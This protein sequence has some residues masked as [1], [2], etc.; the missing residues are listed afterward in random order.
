M[1]KNLRLVLMIIA[2]GLIL[3]PA[4]VLLADRGPSAPQQKKGEKR[5]G[6]ER[7]RFPWEDMFANLPEGEQK[8][9][10]KL[11]ME[12][13]A[14][15]RKEMFKL[16]EARRKKQLDELLALRKAY[17]NA[18]EGAEKE[19]AK[20][21]LRKRIEEN[22]KRHSDRA[23]RRIR[24]MEKQLEQLQKRVDIARKRHE[25]MKKS[26]DAIVE[27]VLKDFTDPAKEPGLQPPRKKK[28]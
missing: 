11:A 28:K 9:L 27:K 17:L 5:H 7:R 21:A 4:G 14:E 2:A 1:K 18:P 16:M 20:A 10:K 6:G 25:M 24:V 22:M 26:Q 19:K 3:C 13:P 8:R 23:E 15:F 12:N